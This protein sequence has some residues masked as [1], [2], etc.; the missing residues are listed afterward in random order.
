MCGG[1]HRGD[2]R[3]RVCAR[4][5]HRC[6][7]AFVC[8]QV[9]AGGGVRVQMWVWV[10]FPHGGLCAFVC[11]HTCPRV[12]EP[13]CISACVG[14]GPSGEKRPPPSGPLRGKGRARLQNVPE[15]KA[16]PPLAPCPEGHASPRWPHHTAHPSPSWAQGK[17]ATLGRG[18]AL[19]PPSLRGSGGSWGA[20]ASSQAPWQQ[21]G[22][23][24][25]RG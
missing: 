25:H 5:V 8:F 13:G 17:E 14:A 2:R 22:S 9:S 15:A 21:A 10:T 6:V 12:R 7:R 11:V 19:A 23:R 16:G 18:A 1:T 24:S 4:E 20:S 3:V